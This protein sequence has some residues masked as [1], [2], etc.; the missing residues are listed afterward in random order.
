MYAKNECGAGHRQ[1]HGAPRGALPAALRH[2]S[3]Q[4]PEPGRVAWQW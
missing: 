1:V 4:V 2:R 3:G